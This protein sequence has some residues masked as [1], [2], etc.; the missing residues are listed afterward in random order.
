MIVS[1]SV[2]PPIVVIMP[3]V[4]HLIVNVQRAVP[5][6]ALKDQENCQILCPYSPPSLASKF[7]NHRDVNCL[8]HRNFAYLSNVCLPCS[9]HSRP[10]AFANLIPCVQQCHKFCSFSWSCSAGGSLNATIGWVVYAQLSA[11]WRVKVEIYNHWPCGELKIKI[12]FL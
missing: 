1:L 12:H 4:N 10:S 9:C 3:T 7:V 6:L 8:L 11:C 2:R 5:V